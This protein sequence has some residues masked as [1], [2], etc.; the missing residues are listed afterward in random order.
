MRIVIFGGTGK[1][2]SAITWDLVRQPEVKMVGLVSRTNSSLKEIKGRLKS[3]KVVIHHLD[4]E[5][6]EKTKKSGGKGLH[7]CSYV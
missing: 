3:N 1:I 4:V 6:K 5:N 7:Q 2:G